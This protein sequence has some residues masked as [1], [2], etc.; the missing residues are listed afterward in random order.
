VKALVDALAPDPAALAAAVAI[1]LMLGDPVY[2]GHPVRLIGRSLQW[3][4][5]LLRLAGLDGYGGGILLFLALMV[6]WLVVLAAVMAAAAGISATLAWVVHAILL[7]TFLALGDLLRHVSRIE[8]A[9]RRHDIADAR[10]KIAALVGRD[11]DRMD[12]A[13]C[14]R[15][16]VE[17]LSE[18]VTDG[19]IS[20]VFWYVLAGLPGITVFKIV[21]TMDS[22]VGYKTPEYLRF[23]WCGARLDDVMNAL[24]ARL[25]WLAIAGV[26]LLTPGLSARK[27]WRIGLE[28]HAVLLGPNSGWSEA[29]TAGALARRIIGPIWLKGIQVTDVWVGD[30]GDPPV[31]TADDVRR[32]MILA[33]AVGVAVA[34]VGIALLSWLAA[35]A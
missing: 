29:A 27:A 31:A 25:S 7:Y 32:A 34:A 35:I 11:T 22:M 6:T 33:A 28:Q 24:P 5:R 9:V 10:R 26:A 23:G 19:F 18:N 1:D 15:A 17:S 30:P 13:A 14:R 20:P 4:E 16:A 3:Y 8:K 2:A 12:G 21:S